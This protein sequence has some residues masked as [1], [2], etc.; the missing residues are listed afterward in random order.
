LPKRWSSNG[1]SPGSADI[2]GSPGTSSATP[3]PSRPSVAS[4]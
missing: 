1:P 3:E 4:P 2:G